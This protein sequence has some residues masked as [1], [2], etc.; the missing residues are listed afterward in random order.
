MHN[1]IYNA[2]Y[3]GIAFGWGWGATPKAKMENNTIKYNKIGI[4][5]AEAPVDGFSY[6]VD[7]FCVS[8]PE[9]LMALDME[10]DEQY[11]TG[12]QNANRYTDV[13]VASAMRY[14][15]EDG[16]LECVTYGNDDHGLQM[17]SSVSNNKRFL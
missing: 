11:V 4:Q 7:D 14:F 9:Y 5:Y 1:D 3:S 8:R 10:T 15:G 17:T 13:Q 16:A 12:F 6:F 2:E